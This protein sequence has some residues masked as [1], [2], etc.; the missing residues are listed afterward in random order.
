MHNYS[1]IINPKKFSKKD[2]L[3]NIKKILPKYLNGIPDRVALSI[4]K[5]I[6][7]TNSKHNI[8]ETGTGASTIAMFLGVILKK[9]KLFTFDTNQAKLDTIKQIMNSI[10]CEPL[11]IDIN[12]YWVPIL[13][14]STNPYIGIKSLKSIKKKFDFCFLDSEHTLINLNDELDLF[15]DLTPDKFYI[16]IDDGH[17]RYKWVNI[18]YVNLIRSRAKLKK[19]S[20]S[21]N[22]CQKFSTEVFKKLKKKF[23]KVKIVE[24]VK[25]Y[26][27]KKDLYYEYYQNIIFKPGER[28]VHHSTFYEVI[29]G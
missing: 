15:F 20:I 29:K 28:K 4:L 26:H 12:D 13:S 18:D 11:N 5:T 1:F 2:L 21:D 6:E 8:L 7:K 19:I 23:K 25:K 27:S 3:L 17:M 14:N 24:T 9:K 22:I 10:I 16:G